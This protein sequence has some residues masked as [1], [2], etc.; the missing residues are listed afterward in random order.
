M[1]SAARGAASALLGF[2][3]FAT[4]DVIVKS[5]GGT[6]PVFQIVFFSVL[7]GFPTVMIMLIRDQA[8]G[9]LTPKHPVLVGVRTG[10]GV[11][12]GLCA[13]YAFTTLPLAET[14]A[15]IFAQ[16]L[17]ITI[18]SVPL[19]GEAVGLRRWIAVAVG[20]LGVV[21]VMQPGVSTL[22]LGHLAAL[23]AATCGA[24][25]SIILR[26]IG[27]EERSV[28]LIL[29]PMLANLV[30]MA[31][32]MPFVYVAPPVEH[33]GLFAV[34]SLLGFGGMLMLIRAYRTSPAAIVAPMQYSQILWAVIFG[35]LL[36]D[37][38]PTWTTALGAAI[39]VA[40]GIYIVLREERGGRTVARPVTT[41]RTLRGDTVAGVRTGDVLRLQG[42]R[43][44]PLNSEE[45]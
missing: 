41:G 26:R 27:G 5:L 43:D 15:I 7:F 32:V 1:T 11:V 8:P 20:L 2:A 29:Y 44:A 40:S 14:Y 17:L 28:V 33:L 19:L 31:M 13:F 9:T 18:L 10:L 39:I 25:V 3:F 35:T 34:I 42:K 12:T 22:S 23:T 38:L 37:E 6:Y 36:F 24:F 21:V 4:H 45:E 16:P 30:C